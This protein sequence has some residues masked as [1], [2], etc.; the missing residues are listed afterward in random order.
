MT[1]PVSSS[2]QLFA[3]DTHTEHSEEYTQ[4]TTAPQ[5]PKKSTTAVMSLLWKAVLFYVHL[6]AELLVKKEQKKNHKIRFSLVLLNPPFSASLPCAADGRF[7]P[8]LQRDGGNL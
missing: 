5:W 8:Q 3:A 1:D 7:S 6:G 4:K 2:S